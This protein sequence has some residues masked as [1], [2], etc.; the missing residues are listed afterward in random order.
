MRF[1]HGKYLTRHQSW[2]YTKSRATNR[3]RSSETGK[4]TLRRT[5]LNNPSDQRRERHY[6]LNR[7]L[8]HCNS[9]YNNPAYKE[10][11]STWGFVGDFIRLRVPPRRST[12][13][14]PMHRSKRPLS[15][16]P[17]ATPPVPHTRHTGS[18]LA[19]WSPPPSIFE[20]RSMYVPWHIDTTTNECGEF[21]G[22]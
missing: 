18:V 16:Q 20:G 22:V 7:K 4:I 5:Y 10:L 13:L 1:A 15:S 14:S 3:E 21:D 17:K 12:L 8:T 6:N 2:I 11:V 19:G 9:K